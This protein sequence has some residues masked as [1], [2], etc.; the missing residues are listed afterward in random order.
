MKVAALLAVFASTLAQSAIV[1][2]PN[3]P[4]TCENKEVFSTSYIGQYKNVKAE[5][6]SCSNHLQRRSEFVKRQTDVCGGACTTNC[7]APAGNGPDPNDCQVIADAL[8]YASQNGEPLF[9]IDAGTSGIYMQ[10][11]TCQS[12]FLNQ[13]SYNET[14]CRSDW[15]E[16]I[17]YVAFN[18]QSQQNAH[19]GN[20]VASDQSWFIQIQLNA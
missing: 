20:C 11:Q 5:V 9:D 8:L 14:Y 3:S 17:E 1:G 7:F 18:C 16:V 2:S 10:Y 12:Y 4:F 13:A 6:V 15:A 19:G